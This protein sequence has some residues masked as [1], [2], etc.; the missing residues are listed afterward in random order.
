MHFLGRDAEQFFEGRA[1]IPLL[2]DVQFARRLAEPPDGQ[3][4]RDG[5]PRHFFAARFDLACEQLVEPKHP[6]QSPSQPDIAEVA[7]P[8]EL[9]AAESHADFF[10]LA[11]LA[12]CR[13]RRRIEQRQLR[14][15]WAIFS[16]E[17]RAE[18]RPTVLFAGLQLAQI[19][20]DAL[21]RSAGRAKRIDERPIGV[22]LP[23]FS[24]FTPPQ[25]HASRSFVRPAR[26][27]PQK[28]TNSRDKVFTT[29]PVDDSGPINIQLTYHSHPK[30]VQNKF[31]QR[32][33]G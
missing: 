2:F 20:D 14:L 18:L 32:N 24:P 15:L 25:K 27:I 28:I 9:H 10:R 11:P 16:C 23:V 7:Q 1:A 5:A 17:M 30:K 29:S 6:P 31:Q 13:I 26:S 4:R 8:F 19:S 12:R 33:L 21:P 22:P 3:D